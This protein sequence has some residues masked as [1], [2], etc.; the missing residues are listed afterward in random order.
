[1]SALR[2]GGNDLEGATKTGLN[3]WNV[4]GDFGTRLLGVQ[5]PNG[6][7]DKFRLGNCMPVVLPQL[8]TG[9]D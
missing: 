4:V 7:S 2:A 6:E 5:H 3:Q 8:H 9:A 1:M